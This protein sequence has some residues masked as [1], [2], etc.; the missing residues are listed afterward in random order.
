VLEG[1]GVVGVLGGHGDVGFALVGDE[2]QAFAAGGGGG[3][4]AGDEVGGLALVDGE[5]VE[6]VALRSPM[7]WTPTSLRSTP[8]TR[9]S[10]VSPPSWVSGAVL[11]RPKRPVARSLASGAGG[12]AGGGGAAHGGRSRHARSVRSGRASAA[13]KSRALTPWSV[14]SRSNTQT[15]SS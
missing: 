4:D 6:E 7:S 14:R 15:S 9:R 3:D 2:L 13:Q 1:E 8:R 11:S 5:G 12:G 10:V